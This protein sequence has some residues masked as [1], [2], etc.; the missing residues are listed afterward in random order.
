MGTDEE[1]LLK[2]IWEEA[3][4][5]DPDKPELFAIMLGSAVKGPNANA[6]AIWL[7]LPR[8]VVR[9]WGKKLREGGIWVGR[10]VEASWLEENGDIALLCDALVARGL[11]T[12]EFGD[13]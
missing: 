1:D 6:L 8:K 13:E 9:M 5:L 10:H 7:G 12:R 3:R 2:Q 11:L 4:R